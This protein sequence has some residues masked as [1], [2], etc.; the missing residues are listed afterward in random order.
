MIFA[1]TLK[2]ASIH[3]STFLLTLDSG[4]DALI[5]NSLESQIPAIMEDRTM[6]RILF[7]FFF[8]V[9]RENDVVEPR[10]L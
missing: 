4:C 9:H 1:A 7:L 3:S 8:F 2:S 5:N 10:V 6:T